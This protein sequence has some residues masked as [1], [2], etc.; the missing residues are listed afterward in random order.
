MCVF[1]APAPQMR[2]PEVRTDAFGFYFLAFVPRITD[3]DEGIE[4][5]RE[6]YVVEAQMVLL[7]GVFQLAFVPEDAFE[8][9]HG[10]RPYSGQHAV[11]H[12][13]SGQQAHLEPHDFPLPVSLCWIFA[14]EATPKEAAL[15]VLVRNNVDVIQKVPFFPTPP[16]AGH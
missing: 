2:C 12:P 7:F 8:G 15:D 11:D 9:C 6:R 3:C 4:I 5:C 14:V 10:M 13:W 16:K 1:L